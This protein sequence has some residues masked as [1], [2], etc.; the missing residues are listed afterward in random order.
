M[1]SIEVEEVKEVVTI[2]K[3]K[4]I[5]TNEELK[6]VVVHSCYTYQ[7]WATILMIRHGRQGC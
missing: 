1:T 4:I 6:M 2:N 3:I 5:N 7:C